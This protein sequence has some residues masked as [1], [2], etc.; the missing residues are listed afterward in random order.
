[1]VWGACS[2]KCQ[3]IEFDLAPRLGELK[4]NNI[5]NMSD[6][7]SA[8]DKINLGKGHRECQGG[9]LN[10]KVNLNR[11]LKNTREPSKLM[12]KRRMFCPA[13]EFRSDWAT[14][15]WGSRWSSI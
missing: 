5:Y 7:Y 14:E 6:G 12:H 11:D 1:M 8:G 13:E 3:H 9:V 4:R 15:K 10:E 2:R